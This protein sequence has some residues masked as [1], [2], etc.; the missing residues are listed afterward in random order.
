MKQHSE[1]SQ[2]KQYKKN[3]KSVIIIDKIKE[4]IASQSINN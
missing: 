2:N 4:I 3:T 1:I